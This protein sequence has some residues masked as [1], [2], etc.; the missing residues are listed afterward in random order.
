MGRVATRPGGAR[1]S[2]QQPLTRA[3]RSLRSSARLWL[4]SRCRMISKKSSPSRMYPRLL[5]MLLKALEGATHCLGL[6]SGLC[7]ARGGHLQSPALPRSAV[8]PT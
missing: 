5:R 2:G 3:W 7:P 6:G 8:F 1:R 4:I